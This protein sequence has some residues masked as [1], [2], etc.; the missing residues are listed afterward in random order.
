MP[1][2]EANLAALRFGIHI[3]L[4]SKRG[5]EGRLYIPAENTK[6]GVIID[7][8][9]PVDLAELL[10]TYQNDVI[11][12]LRSNPE[13]NAVFPGLF[14]NSTQGPANLGTK[15]S[16]RIQV[17]LGI[18]MHLHLF[19]HLA[20]LIYLEAFPGDY[21]V[22]RLLLGNRNLEII[23]SYYT[24]VEKEAAIRQGGQAINALKKD[25]GLDPAN[26]LVVRP[27][28]SKRKQYPPF[29]WGR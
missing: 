15:V 8:P 12:L 2:R 10:R 20:A 6:N 19:R 16:Q 26:M 11:P 13:S 24:G 29:W 7:R 23:K 28:A 22:V 17:H 27:E 14:D 3:L 25:A 5:T 18:D 1:I 4:S 21:E 9:I